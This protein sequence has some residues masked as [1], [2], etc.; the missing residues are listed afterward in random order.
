MSIYAVNSESAKI[1]IDGEEYVISHGLNRELNIQDSIV[2]A[3]Y[4]DFQNDFAK[5]SF[6]NVEKRTTSS[7]TSVASIFYLIF[8]SI[9]FLVGIFFLIRKL[10]A[11]KPEFKK[12]EFKN[13]ISK[14]DDSMEDAGLLAGPKK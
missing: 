9:L 3:I 6:Q 13:P 10:L 11:N 7:N 8:G 5:L 1:W 14:K 2:L 4:L 12:P